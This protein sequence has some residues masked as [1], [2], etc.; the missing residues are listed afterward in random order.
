VR[1][2][3]AVLLALG[4]LGACGRRDFDARVDATASMTHDGAPDSTVIG[5]DEDGDGFPDSIDPCPHVAGDLA[6]TD[7]DGVGDA[8]DPNPTIASE[9][10]LLFATMQA[11]Q[12]AFDDITGSLQEADSLRFGSDAAPILTAA[13]TDV[14]IDVGWEIHA[15]TGTGQHQIAFGVQNDA[16]AEYYFCELNDN[17]A[18]ADAAIFSYDSTA[19]YVKLAGQVPPAFHTGVGLTRLDAGLTHH[20]HTGWVGETYEATASTPAYQGG[21]S[22]RFALNGIDVSVRYLAIIAAN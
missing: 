9:H 11:G 13:L 19:S 16:A 20:L 2:A 6:D 18:G 1:R 15:L 3:A 10:W 21:T 5:H 17:M 22:I 4:V 12:T 14:R 8:C 7:G